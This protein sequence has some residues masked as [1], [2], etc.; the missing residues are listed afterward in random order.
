MATSANAVSRY[1]YVWN[2]QIGRGLITLALQDGSNRRWEVA[3]QLLFLS[4]ATTLNSGKAQ[5]SPQNLLYVDSGIGALHDAGAGH[6]RAASGGES[7][8]PWALGGTAAAAPW[9]REGV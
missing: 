3:D 7:P 9:E 2:P 6:L 5:L 8:F 4:L 1:A